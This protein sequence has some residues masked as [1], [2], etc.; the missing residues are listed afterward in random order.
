[1]VQTP[2]GKITSLARTREVA[3]IHCNCNSCVCEDGENKEAAYP[4]QVSGHQFHLSVSSSSIEVFCRNAFLTYDYLHW[5]FL[6]Q[7]KIQNHIIYEMYGKNLYSF[8]ENFKESLI[9]LW[10]LQSFT[11]LQHQ[12]SNNER[13]SRALE[14][15]QAAG[16]CESWWPRVWYSHGYAQAATL[17]K[18]PGVSAADAGTCDRVVG[19]QWQDF[20]ERHV[21]RRV[22]H[23]AFMWAVSVSL[24]VSRYSQ[25]LL[26]TCKWADRSPLGVGHPCLPLS[27]K[28]YPSYELGLKWYVRLSMILLYLQNITHFLYY[29]PRRILQLCTFVF[30]Y[31]N[32]SE[33]INLGLW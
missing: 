23:I 29:F 14:N 9:C 15:W 16:R 32:K 19:R 1:M 27:P 8:R 22:H 2:F 11:D 21:P 30:A 13:G 6:Q 33:W 24:V 20:P 31:C 25:W 18:H 12:T 28:S 17:R 7:T 10:I 26:L 3:G 5:I 4:E